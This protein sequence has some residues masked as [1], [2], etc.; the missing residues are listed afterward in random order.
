M[1]TPLFKTEEERKEH[2]KVGV[3]VINEFVRV[4]NM[5]SIVQTLREADEY[6]Q[7]VSLDKY[8]EWLI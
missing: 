2:A 1:A 6:T 8:G 7:N 4:L 5:P 3:D